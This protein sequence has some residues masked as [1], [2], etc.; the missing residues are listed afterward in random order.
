MGERRLCYGCMEFKDSLQSVC[1]ICGYADDTS[2]DPNYIEPGTILQEKYVI[3]T[4]IG[5]NSEGAT[6][7]GYNQ[8]IGCRV[9]IR[10][11]MPQGLCTRVR[12]KSLISVD[13]AHVVQYK[14]LLAE[15]ADLNKSLAH[16]RNVAHINPTLDLF[17]AN[18]TVYAV[19]E[20]LEGIT[21][22]DFLK[23]NAGELT[24]KQVSEMFPT[25]FTTI[26]L[27]HNNGII[28]RAISP[29][30]IYV[31]DRNVLRLCAFSISAVRTVHSELPCEIFNGYAAPEQYAPNARQGTWTDVY[32]LCAVLYRILTGC[33][34]TDAMSRMQNDNLCA[35]HV[36]NPNIPRHV[37]RVIMK[38]LSLLTEERIKT[39]TQ[40]VTELFDKP[41]E[42]EPP[43]P[44]PP[45]ES[46]TRHISSQR[47]PVDE[48]YGRDEGRRRN[49]KDYD[50]GAYDTAGN[51]SV[52]DRIK[53]P[54]IIGVLLT[55]VLLII[56]IVVLN[57]LD[58]NPIARDDSTRIETTVIPLTEDTMDNIVTETVAETNDIVP[59]ADSTVPDLVGKN[60]ELKKP[61]VEADGWL[62]LDAIYEYSDEFKAGLIIS[63]SMKPGEPFTSGST[64]TVTVSKGPASIKLPEYKG[65]KLKEYEAELEEL[66]LTNYNTEGVTNYNYSNNEVIEL[67]REAGEEF[68]LTCAETLKIYYAS[69]PETAPA[70][71]SPYIPPAPVPDTPAY[72]ETN[73]EVLDTAP[74]APVE[75]TIS[76][77]NGDSVS[78]S[79]EDSSPAIDSNS[80]VDST[81]AADS[82]L[83][84]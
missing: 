28:H 48:D 23:D 63:Q 78:S 58:M 14:A 42:P 49:F 45:I 32:G 5:A 51:V 19:S 9:L 83:E 81:S 16:M 40:L 12:N 39:V 79:N 67:S 60:Y 46:N 44:L 84:E 70:V 69:N 37:S 29:D 73:V 21:L 26:S 43:K 54:I 41:D 11:Y 80:A 76:T 30:T 15:F 2:Y 27:L 55:C 24:W 65:K 68:D 71:D 35:P 38:G 3:G 1:P 13:P 31:T 7:I 52:I 75:E 8:S 53:I 17:H 59:Q 77:S 47:L 62:Y 6:Y 64:L 18:Q 82:V 10:E 20:Y 74:P 50:E 61:Q 66:G 34:P 22:V 4:K 72:E 57:L 33:K 25:F 56:A 36:M